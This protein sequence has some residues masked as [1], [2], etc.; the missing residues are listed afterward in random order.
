M[1][2]DQWANIEMRSSLQDSGGLDTA[3]NPSCVKGLSSQKVV[4]LQNYCKVVLIENFLFG[5]VLS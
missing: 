5:G 1:L 2:Y 4:F 3:V